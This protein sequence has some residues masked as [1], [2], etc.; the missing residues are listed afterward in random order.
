MDE[1]AGSDEGVPQGT[2][3]GT[4]PGWEAFERD[5]AAALPLLGDECL[6]LA[7]REGNR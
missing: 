3:P 6:V 7:T 2:N 5:L 1:R 4:V